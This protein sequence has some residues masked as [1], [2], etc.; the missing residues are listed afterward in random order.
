[1]TALADAYTVYIHTYAGLGVSPEQDRESQQ[2]RAQSIRAFYSR[3]YLAKR[4]EDAKLMFRWIGMVAA[5][6]KDLERLT[7]TNRFSE[8]Q[9]TIRKMAIEDTE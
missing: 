6:E 2:A 1:M 5:I 9:E 3:I 7:F 4:I 8:L